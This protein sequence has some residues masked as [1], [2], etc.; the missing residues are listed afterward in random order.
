MVHSVRPY[1]DYIVFVDESGDHCIDPIDADYPVFVLSFC[2]FHKDVYTQHL[3]PALRN[4]KNRVFG[5]DLVILHES[6][7]RRKKR[8]FSKMSK[9]PRSLFINLL[10][11]VI[12]Q[13]DFSIVAVVIDKR[14]H[15][16]NG[17]QTEHPY[18]IALIHGLVLLE[19]FL[20]EKGDALETTIVVFESRGAKEDK[21]LELEF[22]RACDGG[23]NKSKPL[24]LEIVIADKK[25]NCEGLQI[26]DLTA[27]PI[28]LS[29]IRPQQPN[30]A[31]E[32]IRTKLFH[33]SGEKG[34]T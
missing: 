10:T 1:S 25:A 11:E 21:E 8:A 29:V 19:Q 7:I 20:E 33:L 24:N 4:L 28:G 12:N 27:R 23:N 26:A 17:S 30:R 9:E 3:T 16:H 6:D 31:F 18:H 34:A 32:V 14:N 13:A 2:I 15:I 5:H 22:R